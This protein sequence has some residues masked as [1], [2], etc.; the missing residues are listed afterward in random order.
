[1]L[2]KGDEPVP[3]YRLEEFLGR[4]AFGEVWR[5]TSPGRASVAL[6][7]LNL[8][9]RQGIKEFRAVQRLKSVRHPHLT[10]T[11]ALWLLDEQGNVLGDDVLD[12]YAAG[13]PAPRAT[14][15]PMS[16]AATGQAPQR[17]TVAI[18]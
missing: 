14:L 7:F 16:S 3:G 13:E 17:L 1:M 12:S 10:S 4:G 8:S 5:A 18:T 2:H 9:E 11:M 15:M 6:K